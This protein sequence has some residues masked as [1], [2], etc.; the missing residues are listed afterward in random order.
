VPAQ[1]LP[2]QQAAKGQRVRDYELD[3]VFS[4]GTARTI[5]GNA[6]PVLDE[7]GASEG[8]LQPLLTSPNTSRLS[9][10]CA[11]HARMQSVTPMSWRSSW[12]RCGGRVHRS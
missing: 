9:R 4:D 6:N 1:E 10:R 12:T 3:I 8:Q 11:R 5:F 7:N 2:V